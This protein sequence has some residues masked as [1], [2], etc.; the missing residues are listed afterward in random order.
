M[1]SQSELAA[2]AAAKEAAKRPFGIRDMIGYMCGDLGNCFI[3]GLVNS[4]ITIYYTNVL[5]ISGAI[6]GTLF[7]LARFFDAFVDVTVGR[8]CDISKIT[9]KG[10]FIPWMVKMKYPFCLICVVLFLPFVPNMPEVA[11]I[12][13]VF[14]TYVVY[15]VLNSCIN[16]PYGSMAAAIS[17]DPNH[18]VTLSTFRSIGSGIGGA[19][20]GFMIPILMY[21]TSDSGR[22]ILS[23]QHFFYI[24]IG[25]AILAFISYN[26]TTHLTTE[27][28]VVAKK[29]KIPASKMFK[30]IISDRA[31]M[32]L[33]IVDLFIV[34]NQQLAGVNATYLFND[35]FQNKQALSVA[36]LFTYGTVIVLAPFATMLTKRFGKKEASV[37]ALFFSVAMYLIMYFMHITNPWLYLVLLFIATLGAGLFN[38][39]V[40][41]F[42]TDVIDYHQMVTGLREDGTV[43]GVNSFSRKIAQALSGSISGYLLVFIAYKSSTTG[44]AVQSAA[45]VEHIYTMANLTPVIT[46]T[47]AG[48]VLLFMYPLNRKKTQEMAV[49]LAKINGTDVKDEAK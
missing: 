11:K 13:Y 47:I 26:F 36:L 24:S 19:L 32:V 38:L 5:G 25:C 9:A 37:V 15:G 3:L 40:W 29:E 42:I 18:R 49:T 7:L 20:T 28:V 27:R 35:Y 8:L 1:L 14:V 46:L 45:T 34:I 17:S 41:A 10:R 4:F 2:E 44:G 33:V 6:I 48:L 12:G 31:V 22:Q 16:I 23:G 30:S 21:T 43:Y 39:M